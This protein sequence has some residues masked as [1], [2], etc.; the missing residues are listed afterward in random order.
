MTILNPKSVAVIGASRD[1]DSVGYAV[2]S[3]LIFGGFRGKVYAVN[4]NA[5]NILG[6][7]C[8]KSVEN[9]KEKV[10]LAVI[11]TPKN[12]VKN[13]L[14][15]CANKKVESAVI[16]T[17][18]FSEVGKDGKILE[19]EIKNIA[20]K[21]KIKIIG[22]NCLGVINPHVKLNASFSPIMP[23]QGNIGFISQSGAIIDSIIDWSIKENLG[24]SMI[25]SSGNSALL[26]IEDFL[27][28]LAKDKNTKIITAYVESIKNGKKFIEIAKKVSKIK[29]IIVLKA[30]ISK[31]SAEATKSH[32]GSL[33]GNNEVYKAAFK[34]SGVY[35][36]GSIEELFDVAKAYSYQKKTD[37]KIAV[38]TNAGGLGV[39]T[40]DYCSVYDV[41][42]VKFKNSTLKKLDF[43]KQINKNYS[44]SNPLD[45]VGDALPKSYESA[46]NIVLS[47]DYVKGL[48]V[49]QT[50]Q[51]MT[52]PIE[53]SEIIIKA[54]KRFPSKPIICVFMK[55]IL[56]EKSI[57]LLEKN[58]IPVYEDPKR[59]VKAMKFLVS[60]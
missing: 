28:I 16:I 42:L 58:K 12:I 26:G 31:I 19:Q 41:N 39:L 13:I 8:Y 36:V 25:I 29:P 20:E 57:E 7:K 24:F 50:M 3:N 4:P 10:E 22:P 17:A 38:I 18:G 37:N 44:R 56:S 40:A 51:K 54:K 23:K 48:I 55:G 27:E 33:A 6:K 35:Q 14:L 34:Q 2:L 32:T 1:K 59:A 30:G 47:G 11:V 53:N 5:K 43:S 46:I 21:N 49:I 15:S 60:D 52:S 9:I 45:I